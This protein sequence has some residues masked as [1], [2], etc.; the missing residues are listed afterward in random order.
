M[1][2]RQFPLR[3]GFFLVP[4]LL[5]GLQNPAAQTTVQ[6]RSALR[7]AATRID[8]LEPLAIGNDP[9][10]P[11]TPIPPSG[12]AEGQLANSDYPA[13]AL[14]DLLSD[15]S[16]RIRTLALEL[17]FR[18]R[19]PQFLPLIAGL[20]GDNDTSF[21]HIVLFNF[22]ANGP[23]DSKREPQSVAA[24]ATRMLSFYGVR[25]SF[26]EFWAARKDL[27]YWFD[28][29]RSQLIT[30]G[31]QSSPNPGLWQRLAPFRKMIDGFPEID[32]N[33]YRIWLQTEYRE[34]A[35]ATNS[36]LAEAV[37][38]L[39]RENVLKL[40]EG[41]PPSKDPDLQ[42]S[43][44][45]EKYRYA[46]RVVLKYAGTILQPSDA[47]R[48]AATVDR[49]R[50]RVKTHPIP[51]TFISPAYAVI[52]AQLK[53]DNASEILH[54][55]IDFETGKWSGAAR[56]ELAGALLRFRGA[57]ERE[58]L[59]DFFY[60]EPISPIGPLAQLAFIDS[61]ETRDREKFYDILNDPRMPQVSIWLITTAYTQFH[62]LP[63]KMLIDWFFA[64]DHKQEDTT[65]YS[66]E[67]F[68]RITWR[69]EF[70][71]EILRDRRL[72]SLPV[73]VL[74]QLQ[75]EL[76]TRYRIPKSFVDSFPHLD[77]FGNPSPPTDAHELAA[78]VQQGAQ[79]VS[80]QYRYR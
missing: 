57:E 78:F 21:E 67:Y 35:I 26:P 77:R 25:G 14:A 20:A 48:I 66:V 36:D 65:V 1:K 41:A 50:A 7:D 53:P 55:E 47:T 13:A 51:E 8:L 22:R 79:F 38:Q 76:V 19:R 40:L 60:N 64:H 46:A 52:Q 23:P 70:F 16:P 4:L 12:S 5:L 37:R 6:V 43:W 32:R 54:R 39:G 42:P 63:D 72:Q 15:P 31:G 49:E 9:G 68:F 11:G 30:T 59:H 29:L 45:P 61:L 18:K 10:G 3:C 74:H 27:P 24:F 80:D 44:N 58:W 2:G 75:Q 33:L 56:G 34:P 69:P 71:L 28:W 73:S 62:D 17:L